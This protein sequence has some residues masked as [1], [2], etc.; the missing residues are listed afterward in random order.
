[1]NIPDPADPS[2]LEATLLGLVAARGPDKSVCPTEIARAF[3]AEP[4]PDAWRRHL[5]AVRRAAVR[6]AE[7]G[8][9]DILRK[10]KPVPPAEARGVIR[11]RIRPGDEGG[12]ASGPALGD[13]S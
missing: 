8:R 7:A 9:I 5:T 6:L 4:G 2:S 10:G 1:M 3:C 12:E 11:L 13:P